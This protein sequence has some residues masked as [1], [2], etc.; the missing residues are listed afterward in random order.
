[1]LLI[2]N[3]LDG[4]EL[5]APDE[6]LCG[7]CFEKKATWKCYACGPPGQPTPAYYCDGHRDNPPEHDCEKEKTHR[8]IF[9][10]LVKV[11]MDD[12]TRRN[13]F[14]VTVKPKMEQFKQRLIAERD[15]LSLYENTAKDKIDRKLELLMEQFVIEIE[16]RRKNIK[17]EV[18][19]QVIERRAR[20]REQEDW[21]A[22]EL[23][24]KYDAYRRHHEAVDI[25][26]RN[27]THDRYQDQLQSAA[28]VKLLE[29][30][31]MDLL[32]KVREY[33]PL[34]G[35]YVEVETEMSIKSIINSMFSH[36]ITMK[37]TM[38]EPCRMFRPLTPGITQLYKA[39]R[40]GNWCLHNMP[41]VVVP[42]PDYAEN[43]GDA[44][45]A[46]LRTECAIAL[47]S[48]HAQRAESL[49]QLSNQ[50]GLMKGA[51]GVVRR[52]C[53][54]YL[55]DLN[56]GTSGTTPKLVRQTA[57]ILELTVHST[58][59][60]ST[61]IDKGE[62]FDYF[63]KEM[64]SEGILHVVGSGRKYCFHMKDYASL[65][66]LE[67][68]ITEQKYD[69][70][71]M[72]RIETKR[73]SNMIISF[74]DEIDMEP[75]VVDGNAE[76]NAEIYQMDHNYDFVS[77]Q[78]LCTEV[79]IDEASNYQLEMKAFE[80]FQRSLVHPEFGCMLKSLLSDSEEFKVEYLRVFDDRH[81]WSWSGKITCGGENLADKA[82][83]VQNTR[84]HFPIPKFNNE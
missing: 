81:P 66:E 56:D 53:V 10:E 62:I 68:F 25:L 61:I 60:S 73:R 75:M 67:S 31:I 37:S 27:P 30:N 82:K 40:I 22:K 44:I 33:K 5:V 28:D 8:V 79:W 2:D 11:E 65:G 38:A 57:N 69:Q 17:E 54:R 48:G 39:S 16:R 34:I 21:V 45:Q 13:H 15:S 72:G 78:P 18:E 64:Q 24:K 76:L 51:D 80:P 3:Q 29:D 70:E 74:V 7:E 41:M 59:T 77:Q 63:K 6:L 58:A 84:G 19:K 47:A 12:E 42:H 20:I 49:H 23:S 35:P 14:E 46:Q 83:S 36:K 43:N 71:R 52:I 32:N 50:I 26:R 4:L 1:M 9:H 55:D